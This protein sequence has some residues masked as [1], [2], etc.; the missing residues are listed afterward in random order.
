MPTFRDLWIWQEAN[1]LMVEI[2]EF[3][4]NLPA[5]ERFRKRDQIERSSSSVEYWR[6]RTLQGLQRLQ[7]FV[8]N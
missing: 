1:K 4:K 8:S 3:A 2:H 7:N 6:V 5:E